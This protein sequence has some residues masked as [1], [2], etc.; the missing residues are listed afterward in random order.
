MKYQIR[1]GSVTL[2][3]N[4]ILEEINIE[5][6]DRSK[7]GIVGKNGAGKTTLLKA[8]IDNN[9]LDEGVGNDKFTITKI[10]NINIGYLEQ[11]NLSDES[12]SMLDELYKSFSNL[13]NMEKKLNKLINLMSNNYS[14]DIVNSYTELEDKYRLLGG[15]TYKK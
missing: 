3:T 2:G 5:I 9:L 4:T 7:I 6:T 15:Y 12:I 13:V 10:G 14:D 8:I 11:I 1:N